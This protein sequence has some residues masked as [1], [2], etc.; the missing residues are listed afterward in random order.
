MKPAMEQHRI[1]LTPLLSASDPTVS[2]DKSS[3]SVDAD[4]LDARKSYDVW[5]DEE[6][7]E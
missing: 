2:V 7:E 6:E 5:E 3:E 1:A 4:K